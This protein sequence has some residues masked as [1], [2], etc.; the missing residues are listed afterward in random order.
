MLYR[1]ELVK[2]EVMPEE[3]GMQNIIRKVEWNIIFEDEH[4]G[5]TSQASIHTV[6]PN[7]IDTFTDISDVTQTQILDW[8]TA[9]QGGQLFINKL[10]ALHQDEIIFKNKLVG[11]VEYDLNQLGE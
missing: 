8:A 5:V 1:K 6:L 9:E 2:V 11:V 10:M 7:P 3:N 4:T